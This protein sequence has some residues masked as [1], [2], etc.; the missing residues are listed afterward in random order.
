VLFIVIII[1]FAMLSANSQHKMIS[2]HGRV[3][4]YLLT[5]AW[6]Y[7]LVG[8]IIWG[9]RKKKASLREIVGGRWNSVEDFLL[10]LAVAFG[11]WLVAAGV[12]AGLSYALG[13][14]SPAQVEQAKK[15]L[16]PLLPQ[17]GLELGLWLALSATAGFCEEIMF[18]GYLQKQ[19]KA[20]TRSSAVAVV[21]QAL[22]FGVAHAYQGGRR[23]FLI[24]AYGAL[25]G[26]LAVWRKSLRPGMLGHTIQDSFSGLAFRLLK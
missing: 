19:F 8:Y 25:F 18:R 10:D 12:L 23:I 11:F 26:I 20:A 16:G 3:P 13:L 1:V 14:A 17:T 5:M 9:A 2:K 4:A 22:I 6:E 21:L 15:Q 24:A 7:V